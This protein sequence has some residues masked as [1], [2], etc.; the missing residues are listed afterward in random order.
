MRPTGRLPNSSIPRPKTVGMPPALHAAPNFGGRESHC[1]RVRCSLHPLS[2]ALLATS[3]GAET[4]T[5]PCKGGIRRDLRDRSPGA[6]RRP[7]FWGESATLAVL[8]VLRLQFNEK[9]LST[10]PIYGSFH[11]NSALDRGR[12]SMA[13]NFPN[14]ALSPPKLGAVRSAGGTVAKLGAGAV[15]WGRNFSKFHKRVFPK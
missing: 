15:A 11:R 4:P 13:Q 6:P 3:P 9:R 10:R 12:D 1:C 2:H 5:P 7:Q 8:C 14:Y